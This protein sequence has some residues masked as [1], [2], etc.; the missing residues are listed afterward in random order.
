MEVKKCLNCG[1]EVSQVKGKRDRLYCDQNCKSV[2]FRKTKPK[3]KKYVQKE[4]FE[5]ILNENVELKRKLSEVKVTDLTKPT[6]EVKPIEVKKTNYSVN[7]ELLSK[8]KEVELEKIPKERD[9]Q[10]GRKVWQAD[11]NKRIAALKAQ[12]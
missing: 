7:T 12:L 5:R 11:Q 9:T 4:T 10:F 2:Y 6:I 8:I 3:E 1:K